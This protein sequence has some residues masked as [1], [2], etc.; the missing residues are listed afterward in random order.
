MNC[1]EVQNYLLFFKKNGI[2]DTHLTEALSLC[3]CEKK[4]FL[5]TFAAS[6][7]PTHFLIS[8]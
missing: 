1:D 2:P 8:F 7:L 6:N 5:F 4:V 3:F